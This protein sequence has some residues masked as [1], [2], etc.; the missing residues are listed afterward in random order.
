MTTDE[1]AFMMDIEIGKMV[2]EM[3]ARLGK[4]FPPPSD[5]PLSEGHRV[6][7]RLKNGYVRVEM[8]IPFDGETYGWCVGERPPEGVPPE[9][10]AAG[11]QDY[12]DTRYPA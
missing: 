12:F 7:V 10:F 4:P 8:R 5:W 2:G 11:I 6:P 3:T 1:T 9:Q